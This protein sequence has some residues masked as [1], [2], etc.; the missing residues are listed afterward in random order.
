[1]GSLPSVHLGFVVRAQPT[2]QSLP[3]TVHPGLKRLDIKLTTYL[4]LLLRLRMGGIKHPLPHTP[5]WRAK[6]LYLLSVPRK[7]CF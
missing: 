2:V 4:H 6:K 3:G 7:R 1:M 5:L